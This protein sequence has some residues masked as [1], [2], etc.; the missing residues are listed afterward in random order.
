MGIAA[1]EGTMAA[2]G[3]K[4]HWGKLP[5]GRHWTFALSGSGVLNLYLPKIAER[6]STASE[7][8]KAG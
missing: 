5:R 3:I 7:W 4:P 6:P 2:R 8:H 1:S